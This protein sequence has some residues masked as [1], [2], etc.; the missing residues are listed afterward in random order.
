[1]S[2]ETS[3]GWQEGRELHLANCLSLHVLSQLD[4]LYLEIDRG[5]A[6]RWNILGFFQENQ[7]VGRDSCWNLEDHGACGPRRA[8]GEVERQSRIRRWCAGYVTGFQAN[9]VTIVGVELVGRGIIDLQRHYHVAH[10]RRRLMPVATPF[11]RCGGN[12]PV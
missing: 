11:Q 10:A 1:M 9:V 2:E 5:L 12:C 3:I 4:L 8:T 7:R 6:H